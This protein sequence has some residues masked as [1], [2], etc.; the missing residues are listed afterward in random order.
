MLAV[1]ERHDSHAHLRNAL[2]QVSDERDLW[3]GIPM[4]LE[5][6]RLVIEPRYPNAELLMKMGN[7]PLE[8]PPERKLERVRNRFWSSRKLCE[9]V[10]FERDG[11]IDWGVVPGVHHFEF[12]LRT[13]GCSDAWGIEQE[14]KAIRT[15]AEL[16][17]HRQFKLY[18]LTGMFLESSPRSGITYCF[19]KLRPTVAIGKRG[20]D[21]TR[22][23][24][25]L[26]QHPIAHYEG[27]WAGAM[28]PTDDVIAALATMR[29]DE[30]MFWKR[31][32]QHPAW[33][34]NAG[35]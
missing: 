1:L 20:T 7:T 4:P 16:V 27:S 11:K 29:G 28:C 31:S 25:C 21:G 2:R 5:G 12:D 13:M 9:I 19:R 32:T 22:I 23:L 26:C 15:L 8:P 6:E 14:A 18:M 17:N 3:A 30:H 35:L 10:I 33:V 34:P 24:A